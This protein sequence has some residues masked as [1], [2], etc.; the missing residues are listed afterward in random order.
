MQTQRKLNLTV[1]VA[2]S[3][4]THS[5]DNTDMFYF[6]PCGKSYMKKS[7]TWYARHIS[8]KTKYIHVNTN[9]SGIKP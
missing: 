4:V 8:L 1:D 2:L 9:C 3:D 6:C 7:K 5:D